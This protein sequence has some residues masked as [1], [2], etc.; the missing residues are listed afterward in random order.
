MAANGPLEKSSVLHPSV[1]SRSKSSSSIR[2]WGAMKSTAPSTIGFFMGVPT[3]ASAPLRCGEKM[4]AL[5]Y[6]FGFLK[7]PSV[8]P[9]FGGKVG[10]L[11]SCGLLSFSFS[12]S[13]WA[14]RP[15]FLR[16]RPVIAGTDSAALGRI[17]GIPKALA[18]FSSIKSISSVRRGDVMEKIGHFLLGSVFRVTAGSSPGGCP[19]EKFGLRYEAFRDGGIV[20]ILRL[21]GTYSTARVDVR[22]EFQPGGDH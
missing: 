12:R 1:C 18:C 16:G 21:L 8:T 2:P 17:G 11:P 7:R 22:L 13:L 15:R 6:G 20:R 10:A 9:P 4:N 5:R 14:R 19:I 3:W